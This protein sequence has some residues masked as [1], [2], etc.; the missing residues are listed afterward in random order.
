M[1]YSSALILWKILLSLAWTH[2]LLYIILV[3][4]LPMCVATPSLTLWWL[5]VVQG[6]LLSRSH[7]PVRPQLWDIIQL[8]L[9]ARSLLSLWISA[10]GCS[11][12]PP[13]IPD[14]QPSTD[15]NPLSGCSFWHNS[16]CFRPCLCFH[17]RYYVYSSRGY[18]G[19]L[20]QCSKCD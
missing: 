13:E 6:T 18:G 10:L 1:D 3:Q 17:P 16:S 2:G 8:Q 11:V 19:R 20:K 4:T 5:G 12:L 14:F 15:V 9:V 7:S